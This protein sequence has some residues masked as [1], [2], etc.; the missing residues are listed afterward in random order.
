VVEEIAVGSIEVPAP[1]HRG[2]GAAP[3]RGIRNADH[4]GIEH[5]RVLPKHPLDLG[6][7]DIFAAAG[8]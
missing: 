1:D 8:D 2:H 6:R 3:P 7:V 5:R 4:S